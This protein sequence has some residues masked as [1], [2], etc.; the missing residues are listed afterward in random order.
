[1]ALLVGLLAGGGVFAYFVYWH[2][3]LIPKKLVAFH[4]EVGVARREPHSGRAP[5]PSPPP[6]AL[7]GGSQREEAPGNARTRSAPSAVGLLAGRHP[8]PLQR[9]TSSPCTTRPLAP[10]LAGLL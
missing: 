7:G 4:T 2:Q 9:C 6:I 1:M 8:G 5:L 10:S 3:A